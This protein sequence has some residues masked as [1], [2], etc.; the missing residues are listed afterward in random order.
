[1]KKTDTSEG[2]VSRKH[3]IRVEENGVI[4]AIG[5]KLTTYRLMAKEIVDKS[6]KILKLK[7]SEHKCL[8]GDYP[9]FGGDFEYENKNIYF[10]NEKN[11][12]EKDFGI[13]EETSSFIVKQLGSEVKILD[14]ILI[15]HGVEKTRYEKKVLMMMMDI[16]KPFRNI[17]QIILATFF[18]VYF[19]TLSNLSRLSKTSLRNLTNMAK[20]MQIVIIAKINQ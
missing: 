6:I 9:V 16:S 20:K 1:M 17:R 2:K 13:D 3:L 4:T 18:R 7:K 11:R 12:L 10:Q 8:T 15:Q 5:G 14:P 19:R